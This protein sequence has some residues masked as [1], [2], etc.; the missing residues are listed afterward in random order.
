MDQNFFLLFGIFMIF[1][2][3]L[4][5]HNVVLAS[6]EINHVYPDLSET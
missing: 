3:F 4:V 1:K 6:L 5:K 2:A